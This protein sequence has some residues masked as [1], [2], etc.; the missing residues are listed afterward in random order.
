[1][2]IFC[3]SYRGKEA[4]GIDSGVAQGMST[5]SAKF[6]W[7]GYT[8]RRTKHPYWSKTHFHFLYLITSSSWRL[9]ERSQTD[10]HD[11]NCVQDSEQQ[12]PFLFIYAFTSF[13]VVIFSLLATCFLLWI[14]SNSLTIFLTF[15]PFFSV[16][17]ALYITYKNV[18]KSNKG[19]RNYRKS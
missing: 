14:N 13:V 5:F 7:R 12:Q 17:K 6:C 19:T 11:G 9:P 4:K 2:D 10:Y 3:S 15:S 1:M 18:E 8:E 16:M